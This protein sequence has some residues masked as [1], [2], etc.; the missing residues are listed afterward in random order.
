MFLTGGLAAAALAWQE[1][2]AWGL[3][4]LALALAAVV[5]FGKRISP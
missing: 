1:R 5:G 4:A 3:G 2:S